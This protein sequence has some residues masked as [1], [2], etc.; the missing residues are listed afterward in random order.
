MMLAHIAGVP[1][2]EWLG[3]FPVTAYYAY[4]AAKRRTAVRTQRLETVTVSRSRSTSHASSCA[5]LKG[6]AKR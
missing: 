1:L 6:L 4:A 2:E 5:S 3:V